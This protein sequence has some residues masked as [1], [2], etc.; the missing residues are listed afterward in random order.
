M[1][2]FMTRLFGIGVLAVTAFVLP[3]ATAGDAGDLK[4]DFAT[5]LGADTWTIRF[6]GKGKFSV[7]MA[8]KEVVAGTYKVAKDLVQFTDESGELAGK[9]DAQTGKYKWMLKD[10]KLTFKKVAD[11]NEGRDMAL[12][13]APWTLTTQ[14]PEKKPADKSIGAKKINA[15][16]DLGA[17][18]G[19]FFTNGATSGFGREEP[20]TKLK[21]PGFHF[22]K[23]PRGKL[24]GVGVP[25]DLGFYSI[26]DAE[27]KNLAGLKNL[28]GLYLAETQVT[29]LGLKELAGLKNLSTLVLM[30]TKV[31]DKG[32][33]ELAGLENLTTLVLNNLPVTNA[34]LKELA[35][36]KNLS[37]LGLSSTK[38]TDEGV[39][40]LRKAL[41]KCQIV[42]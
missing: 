24:P 9:D 41:P 2:F 21:M 32:L 31:T 4:G 39:K 27:L 37:V 35:G 29:D 5:K 7:A 34:G 15:Y 16:Q 33:K 19:S 22:R 38:V 26:S 17:T 42:R 30:R 6:D 36:L 18:Y 40:E 28:S 14:A 12:T 11:K 1:E 10:G 3:A 23:M 13:A 8:K 25:F 20:T